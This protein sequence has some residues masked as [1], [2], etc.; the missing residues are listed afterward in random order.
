M[1]G[2]VGSKLN[3]RG[4]GLVGSL[5]TDGQLLT[6][7]GAGVSHVFEDAAG[8]GK[9]GQVVYT[10]Y[11]GQQQE[12][13]IDDADAS[14]SFLVTITP[15]AS[16]SKILVFGHIQ[17]THASNYGG[18]GIWFTREIS[19]GATTEIATG[20][21]GTNAQNNFHSQT[22]NTYGATSSEGAS[23]PAPFSFVDSP[24]TTSATTYRLQMRGVAGTANMRVGGS[25]T[26]G[27]KFITPFTAMEILA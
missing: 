20:T 13:S 2:I 11:D 9:I 18:F 25:T 14:T 6:S 4:S 3:I 8:G 5:G 7:S 24:S 19:G 22:M 10:A 1:S 26:T 16:S 27:Q 23:A 17:C 15:S 21:G 12:S